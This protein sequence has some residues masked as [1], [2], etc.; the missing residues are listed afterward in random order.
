MVHNNNNSG[1]GRG[2]S[3]M[4]SSQP[5][6]NMAAQNVNNS[7]Q[8]SMP[9]LPQPIPSISAA[10]NNSSSDL[11]GTCNS[12]TAARAEELEGCNTRKEGLSTLPWSDLC[13][14]TVNRILAQGLEGPLTGVRRRRLP[15]VNCGRDWLIGS[16]TSGAVWEVFHVNLVQL[17]GTH[18][19]PAVF[20]SLQCIQEE[21]ANEAAIL[22]LYL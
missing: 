9:S 18:L 16:L 19:E 6:G 4:G 3:Q 20:A 13:L 7:G 5:A 10:S 22:H 8:P 1:S 12:I 11:C 17:N 14:A 21:G 2:E 15:E